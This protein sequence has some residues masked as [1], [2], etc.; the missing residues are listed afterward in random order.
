MDQERAPAAAALEGH[1]VLLRELANSLECAQVAVAESDVRQI[2]FQTA[3]QRDLCEKLR[4]LRMQPVPCQ[5]LPKLARRQLENEKPAGMGERGP[6]LAAELAEVEM[7][8]AHLNRSYEAL[9]RRARRTID[10]FCRVLANSALTY[11][12][13]QRERGDGRLQF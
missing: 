8:V 2:K 11:A 9:L 1:L 6:A 3:R 13:P 4:P 5:D 12:P 10:I 7:K